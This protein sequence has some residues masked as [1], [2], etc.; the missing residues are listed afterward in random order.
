MLKI[1]PKND[2][3]A[4]SFQY[5]ETNFIAYMTAG[6]PSVSET[7]DILK[8]LTRN[9]VDIIELGYPFS[10]PTADGP[11]I[12]EAS[13]TALENGFGRE[14][15][16]AILRTFRQS[17]T[18]TPI[19]VFSYFNPIF[20]HGVRRFCERIK[21]CGGDGL[22]IV[23]LPWEE[24]GELRP[25]LDELGLHLIQ[26]IAPTTPAERAR[27][28]LANATGFIYQISLRGVTGMRSELAVDVV[29]QIKQTRK[30]TTLPIALGFG[31]SQREQIRTVLQ[32]VDGIIIGSAIIN[33][34]AN[35]AP[36]YEPMLSKYIKELSSAI[37]NESLTD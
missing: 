5:N 27:Q 20:R 16:F 25:I 30:L 12:Q 22:L 18:F 17:N 33:V 3:I 28:I 4:N 23:D 6:Y 9:G 29:Q 35:N 1:D 24:Q 26:L 11:V 37:H 15:Y 2:R 10:D 8:I 34:I 14:D 36:N 21:E 13:H 7:V 32:S 19:V 31:L